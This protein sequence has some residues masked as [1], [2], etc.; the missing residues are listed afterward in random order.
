MICHSFHQAKKRL[1]VKQQ[2]QQQTKMKMWS[3][4]S[5]TAGGVCNEYLPLGILR[6]V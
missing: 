2:Q 3:S 6:T 4:H 1:L 5:Y